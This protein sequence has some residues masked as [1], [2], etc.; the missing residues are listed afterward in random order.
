MLSELNRKL[1]ICVALN[2]K[3][4]KFYLFWSYVTSENGEKCYVTLEKALKT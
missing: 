1:P 2:I 4:L 3:Y